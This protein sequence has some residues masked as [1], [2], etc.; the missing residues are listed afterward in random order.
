MLAPNDDTGRHPGPTRR[1]HLHRQYH[2]IELQALAFVNRHHANLSRALITDFDFVANVIHKS[3]RTKLPLIVLGWLVIRDSHEMLKLNCLSFGTLIQNQASHRFDR[4]TIAVGDQIGSQPSCGQ[5][6]RFCILAF[7]GWAFWLQTEPLRQR[8]VRKMEPGHAI[9]G[10]IG[11]R[12]CRQHQLDRRRIGDRITTFFTGRNP[13]LL[14]TSDQGP[15]LRVGPY[16]HANV[17]MAGNRFE[18]VAN[19]ADRLVDHLAIASAILFRV[20]ELLLGTALAGHLYRHV[21]R[22]IGAIG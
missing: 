11:K 7:V 16:D 13:S 4:R 3:R 22:Q 8:T 1:L 6:S 12:Q 20:G 17:M 19:F 5:L 2:D 10:V 14:Q 15:N 18:Q 9:A 21:A